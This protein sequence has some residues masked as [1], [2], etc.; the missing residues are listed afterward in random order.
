M[1]RHRIGGRSNGAPER[2]YVRLRLLDG[3][4]LSVDGELVEV[5]ASAQR[6]LALL[7]LNPRAVRRAYV[8]G[9]LWPDSSE[10]RASGCLRSALWRVHR[11]CP[12]AIDV[13]AGRIRLATEVR[14]DVE[15]EVAVAERLTRGER[16][17]GDLRVNAAAFLGELLPDWYDEWLTPYRERFR[18]LRLHALEALSEQLRIRRRYAAAIDA[19]LVAVH[20]EPTRETAQRVLIRAYLAEGNRSEARRQYE[21]YCEA[22]REDLGVD[23]TGSLRQLLDGEEALAPPPSR[24]DGAVTFP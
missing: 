10:D 24:C 14:A 8:A 9:T 4:E 19:A 12:G 13:L 7:A 6:L 1:S 18:Q 17:D 23:P 15:E 5:P 3:F 21:M 2:R 11:S 22:L 20:A 16:N